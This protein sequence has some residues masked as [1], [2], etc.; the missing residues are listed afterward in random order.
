MVTI[1]NFIKLAGIAQLCLVAASFFIPKC[2]NWKESMKGANKLTLQLFATYACY[3]LGMHFF[4]GIISL[5]AANELLRG[6]VLSIGLCALMFI[7]WSVRILLQFF[8][9]DRSCIPQ[10]KFNRLAEGVLIV[11]FACLSAIYG[12]A[13]WRNLL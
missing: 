13:L 10:T 2:L 5:C 8:C 3:I 6:D 7:W 4:F 11:M 9:F 12:A 1:E